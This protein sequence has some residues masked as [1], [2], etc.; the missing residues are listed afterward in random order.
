M[1]LDWMIPF[2]LTARTI[3][4]LLAWLSH[5]ESVKRREGEDLKEE[6]MGG[7]DAAS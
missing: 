7:R 5:G 6:A 2:F 1:S 4:S 3:G